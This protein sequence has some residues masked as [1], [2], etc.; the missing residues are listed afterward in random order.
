MVVKDIGRKSFSNTLTA[1][2]LKPAR[3]MA[4]GNKQ[5]NISYIYLAIYSMLLKDNFN[6]LTKMGLDIYKLLLKTKKAS[7]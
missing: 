4:A 3:T 7:Q 1:T 2:D 6:F 5:L